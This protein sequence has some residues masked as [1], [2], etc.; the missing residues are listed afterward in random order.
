MRVATLL[1]LGWLLL[2]VAGRSD[3]PPGHQ[4]DVGAIC[5]DCHDLDGA[6]EARFQHLPVQQGQCDDCHNPHVSRFAGLLNQQPGSLCITCHGQI[7]NDL[8]KTEVH[9]PV[10]QGKCTYCHLPHGGNNRG[11]L[12]E[13]GV[14]LCGTCHTEIAVWKERRNQH[15][16]F[17][18]GRCSTCHEPHSSSEPSLLVASSARICSGCH[19]ADG[20]LREAHSGYPVARA[21]CAQCHDPHSSARDG[22][23]RETVHAPFASGVC[24]TCHLGP[25]SR[26]PFAL[27]STIDQLCG[28]CHGD[29][30]TESLQAPFPHVPAG[31]GQCTEC[32]NP[33]SGVGS[34]MLK[35]D[36]DRLC[37]SCHNPG[38]ALSGEGGR[39]VTHTGDMDCTI[40]HQAHGGERPLLFADNTVD[41]CGSCHTHEHGF[42]HP[43][44][45]DVRD[46]RNGVPMTCRS[47]H[48]IHHAPGERYLHGADQKELCLGC[49]KE[50]GSR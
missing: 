3:L 11:L 13:L 1:I 2:P 36:S 41:L 47:C 19:P 12:V 29:Q 42:T 5:L 8:T 22:L 34:G 20:S 37:V 18:Q 7:R 4:I 14:E 38:G 31:G 33:H 44:G 40:C 35:T 48:G 43:L 27:V 15:A 17:A 28:K 30:V 32:H 45:E 49:H 16:P 10:A 23:F 9:L 39:Y 6:L 21:D 46:P 26:D 24:T 50:I 25:D